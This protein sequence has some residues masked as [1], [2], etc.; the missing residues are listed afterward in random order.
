MALA[1][2]GSAFAQEA[3]QDTV[4]A[5]GSSSLTRAEVKAELLAARQSGTLHERGE[6]YGNWVAS[7]PQP[8][9]RSRA[10]VRAELAIARAAGELDNRGESYGGP[11]R[12]QFASTRNRAD[13]KAE[14]QAAARTRASQGERDPG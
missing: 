12:E 14:A 9:T 6:S 1:A 8:S 13:V 10:D 2:Q 4:P 7:S 5:K 3:L 11:S